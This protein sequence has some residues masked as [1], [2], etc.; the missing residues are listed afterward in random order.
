M[1]PQTKTT[2]KLT[3]DDTR[4]EAI[5]R[6]I[7]YF[8]LQVSGYDCTA[9]TVI[10]VLV[11]AAVTGQTIEAACKELDEMVAGETIRGYL[12]EQIRVDDLHHLEQ[13]VN[14]ALVGGLPRRLWKLNLE[15]AL[16]LHDEP[17]YGHSPELVAL[18]CGG[19]AHKG[20]TRFFRVATAYLIFKD[21]RLT[22]GLLFVRPEDDLAEIVAALGRRLRILGLKVKRL[23]LD[24]GFCSIPVLRHL[25]K[26]G[27]PAILACPIRGKTGGTRG[28]CQGNKSYA[29]QH[30][31]KSNE[32]GSFT[33]SLAIVRSFTTHQRSKRKKRRAIWLV[34]VVLNDQFNPKTV[35]KLYRKRFGIETS[36]RCMRQV[37][38]WTTSRNGAL[39]FLLMSLAFIL[40]NLW[41]ELRWRFCQIKQR[42]R[43]QIDAKRF[44]LQRL[45]TF[46]N[47]AIQKIYGV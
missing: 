36:Y 42:G 13:Q 40:I 31:F 2:L 17:F 18:T 46:L 14:Q 29:T 20:T 35:R 12:N 21:M 3:D 32:N 34:Y 26:S 9:E 39:R 8:P 25:E 11:K 10:D 7:T 23:Y 47:R 33:A 30:T 16:D 41:V 15:I 1:T 4:Q 6:L 45:V 44:E 19:K 22:L 28:L 27:L 5:K 24:K 43:R 37:R 38:A